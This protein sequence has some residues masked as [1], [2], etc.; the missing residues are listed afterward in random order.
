MLSGSAAAL[1]VPATALCAG[2]LVV[3]LLASLATGGA[4]AAAWLPDDVEDI[5]DVEADAEADADVDAEIAASPDAITVT[6][7][8]A[9]AAAGPARR[10]AVVRV[11]DLTLTVELLLDWT[12]CWAPGGA[13]PATTVMADV[14]VAIVL[15]E[16]AEL[17]EP[18]WKG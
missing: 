10:P 2:T 14:M 17:M 6:P 5:A 7:G 3:A 4:G 18:S 9:G 16:G 11:A 12:A 15:A 1:V 8:P 13:G